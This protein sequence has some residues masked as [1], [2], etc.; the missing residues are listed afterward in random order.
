MIPTIFDL[1]FHVVWYGISL[2]KYLLICQGA[3]KWLVRLTVTILFGY[4][5]IQYLRI[6]EV[7]YYYQTFPPPPKL[8]IGTA[9]HRTN[10]GIAPGIPRYIFRRLQ[11]NSE[12]RPLA[13]SC[14]CACLSVCRHGTTRLPLEIQC[15]S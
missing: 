13:P 3:A 4:V 9:N 15:Y 8:F 10:S 2:P 7:L 1:V 6:F 12:K 5:L 14:L 11:Q